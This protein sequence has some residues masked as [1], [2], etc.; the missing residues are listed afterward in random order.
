MAYD[1]QFLYL[2]VHCREAPGVAYPPGE[3]VRPRDPDLSAHDRVDV[4]V[5]LDRDFVTYF[6]LTVDHRGWTGEA[7][8][9][10][11]TWNPT[12][13]VAAAASEGNWTVEAAIPLDQLTGQY[14]KSRDVWAVGIQRT[15]PGVGFQS[16]NT[17]AATE[18]I[19]EGFGYVI[20]Q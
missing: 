2:A 1:D 5:D 6:R 20:F 8:W 13:F 17:P 18:V 16:W 10:D 19:P 12:W 15:V 11:A 4:L 3:G 7:C 14:P 9:G